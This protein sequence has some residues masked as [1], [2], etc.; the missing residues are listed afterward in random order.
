MWLEELVFSVFVSFEFKEEVRR[1]KRDEETGS[2]AAEMASQEAEEH[3]SLMAWNNEENLR[4][5][6]ARWAD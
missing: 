4:M 5:L 3:R 2:K 1:K 6:K